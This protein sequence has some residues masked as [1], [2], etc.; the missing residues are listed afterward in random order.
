[1]SA[2]ACRSTVVSVR[3]VWPVSSAPSW[4]TGTGGPRLED[5]SVP[6]LV[7][8]GKDD[9]LVPLA[10][11]EST[12][13]ALAGSKLVVYDGMGH[14]LPAELWAQMTWEIAE[15]TEKNDDGDGRWRR[16]GREVSAN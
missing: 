8:H 1:M 3:V 15:H 12:A 14:D 16:D 4:R 7:I 6:A 13:A 9:V 11:G 5:V 2:R 10:G